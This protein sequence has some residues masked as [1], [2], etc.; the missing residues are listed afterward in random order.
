M[1]DPG[2]KGPLVFL[3]LVIKAGNH[4]MLVREI[5]ANEEDPD[6]AALV[7]LAFVAGNYCLKF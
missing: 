4:K 3:M 2:P 7:V 1:S 5:E 6:Q